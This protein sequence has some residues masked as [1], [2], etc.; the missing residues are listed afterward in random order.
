MFYAVFFKKPRDFEMS[1]NVLPYDRTSAREI[2]GRSPI[3]IN[4]FLYIL[5]DG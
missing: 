3:K 4:K 2:H 5:L 1:P